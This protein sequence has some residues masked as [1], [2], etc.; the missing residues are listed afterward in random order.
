M[1]RI[2]RNGLI[3]GIVFFALSLLI[4]YYSFNL[5][6]NKSIIVSTPIAICALL[7]NGLFYSRFAKSSKKLKSISIEFLNYEILKLESPANHSIEGHLI[8]GKL[9]LTDKRLIFKSY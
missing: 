7:I 1:M 9:F 3:Y 5:P 4:G 2:F 8:A 6:L